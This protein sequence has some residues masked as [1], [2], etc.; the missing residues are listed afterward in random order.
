MKLGGTRQCKAFTVIKILVFWSKVMKPLQDFKQQNDCDPIYIIQKSRKRPEARRPVREY[1]HKLWHLGFDC[2]GIY[3][4]QPA[5]LWFSNP[6]PQPWTCSPWLGELCIFSYWGSFGSSNITVSCPHSKEN[7]NQEK[8]SRPPHVTFRRYILIF[9]YLFF[10][11]KKDWG[12]SHLS[13]FKPLSP[14]PIEE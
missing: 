9:N 10:C 4:V 3:S 7:A 5:P 12:V 11:Y 1:C 14:P 13:F 8:K 2:L 6:G